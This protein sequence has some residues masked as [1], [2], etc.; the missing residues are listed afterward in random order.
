M[1]VCSDVD[2]IFYNA[3]VSSLTNQEAF[4][5]IDEIVSCFVFLGINSV[6]LFCDN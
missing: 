5:V 1:V 3:T 6:L 2:N 4:A